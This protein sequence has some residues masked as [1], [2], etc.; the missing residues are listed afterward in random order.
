[1]AKKMSSG[2]KGMPKSTGSGA[3]QP[4]QQAEKGKPRMARPQTGDVEG[5]ERIAF[6]GRRTT[7]RLKPVMHANGHVTEY[8]IVVRPDAVAVVAL[9]QGA[10]TTVEVALVS[11]QRPA[12]DRELLEIPAG[13]IEPDER[14]APERA[15]ARELREE[16][17]FEAGTVRKLAAEFPSPGYTSEI[18]HLYVASGLR[19]AAG[20]QQLDPGEEV[21]VVWLPLDEAIAR[22]QRGEIADGKT[23][24][25]L[26]MARDE[27]KSGTVTL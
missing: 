25:G 15:A 9:R 11:Q 26:W 17:G 3:K 13:L 14:N 22:C 27:L 19:E 12:V 2:A 1:M 24:L 20:G 21:R 6:Q 8:E 7:V 18:I 23:L 16:T 10:G 4:K 5:G